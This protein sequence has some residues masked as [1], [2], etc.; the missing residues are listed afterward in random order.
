MLIPSIPDL[1]KL[2][3]VCIDHMNDAV[4]ITEA[5]PF[6]Q[7]GPRIVWVN[8]IFYER[9][10]YS[11]EEVIGNTPRMLQGPGTDRATLDRVREAMTQWRPIRAELLNY[12]K[13]GTSYWNEFEIVPVANEQGW[14]T[15]WVSVQRDTTERKQMEERVHQLAF[16][17]P[18]THLPNRRL[19]NDR[20]SQALAA[21]KRSGRHGALI[22]LD[23]DNFKL[24]NDTHGHDV[25]DALLCQVAAQ[26]K[27]CVRETDTVSRFGGDEFVILLSDLFADQAT[28]LKRA[29]VIAEKIRSA[30]TQAYALTISQNGQAEHL[31][32]HQCS[33][34]LG[35]VMFCGQQ[36]S[37]SD[38][39]KW[40]DTAMYQAKNAGR[41]AIRFYQA[42][43]QV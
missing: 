27:K 8:K 43:G 31:I 20:L 4:V 23:L 14:F 41:N 26:L 37:V 19:M 9:N 3:E 32:E 22:F 10:G 15:H 33:A 13:D 5:E 35:V 2:L 36:A 18:L 34:S 16:Y 17:D 7:P 40:A 6:S 29:S 25:G 24:V 39:L 11:P 30:L 42:K 28:S 1:P 38:L 21:S 12:R